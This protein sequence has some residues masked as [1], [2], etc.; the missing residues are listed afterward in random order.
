MRFQRCDGVLALMLYACSACTDPSLGDDRRGV[1]I[2]RVG[3]APAVESARPLRATALQLG[4]EVRRAFAVPPDDPLRVVVARP[5]SQV[6]LSIGVRGQLPTSPPVRFIVRAKTPDGWQTIFSHSVEGGERWQD[7]LVAAAELPTGAREFEFDTELWEADPELSPF[8]GSVVFSGHP[9]GSEGSRPNIVL[10]SLDTLGAAY[11][12]SEGEL[13]GVSPGID[14]VLR[15]SGSFSRTFAQFGSTLFSHEALFTGRYPGDART[16]RSW[17]ARR[18]LPTSL[19]ERLASHGYLTI[20]VTENSYVSSGFGFATGFDWYDDG[21]AQKKESHFAGYASRTYAQAA[22]I[23]E[24]L[25]RVG[26][27]FLFVHTYQVH[28]PYNPQTPAGKQIAA[29]LSSGDTRGYWGVLLNARRQGD[30]PQAQNERRMRA[31][32]VGGVRDLDAQVEKFFSRVAT[33]DTAEQTLI[34]LTSDH[35]EAFRNGRGT[36]GG[37]HND[38]LRVP[39]GFHWPGHIPARE[40]TAPVELVDVL[41]TILDFAHVPV[42]EE[43]DGRSLA[44]LLRTGED[45]HEAPHSSF[46][47]ARGPRYAIQTERFKLTRRESSGSEKLYDLERDPRETRD[48]AALHPEVLARLSMLLEQRVKA[49][50]DGPSPPADDAEIDSRTLER[51]KALGYV[52]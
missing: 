2:G 37:L 36:H 7:H 28:G 12:G 3:A 14:R 5:A 22:D 34:V 1:L 8:F 6:L 52:E 18:V 13:E 46:S 33:F 15:R 42:P 4:Q 47:I 9:S 38:V 25:Q 26:P 29:R 35:G 23:L 51:L 44:A 19:V 49:L 10:M 21:P 32:Y 27:L 39:L 24:R 16:S 40:N 43:L 11:L 50:G 20:A 31:L 17:K 48:V 41:P 45:P 30:R